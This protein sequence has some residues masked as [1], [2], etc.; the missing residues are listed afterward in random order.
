M[1]YDV[2]KFTFRMFHWYSSG[3]IDVPKPSCFTCEGRA[4]KHKFEGHKAIQITTDETLKNYA[5]T[6]GLQ[7]YMYPH[8]THT[9]VPDHSFSWPRPFDTLHCVA[10]S[11]GWDPQCNQCM[12]DLW[13]EDSSTLAGSTHRTLLCCACEHQHH[14]HTT[15]TRSLNTGKAGHCHFLCLMW[16]LIHRLERN[17]PSSCVYLAR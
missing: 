6:S 8:S 16:L 12:S 7:K 9:M 15:Q 11:Y 5:T 4:H 10:W 3:Y 2:T 14:F 1:V 17:H 13:T